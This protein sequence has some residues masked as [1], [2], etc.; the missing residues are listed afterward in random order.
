MVKVRVRGLV[1]MVRVGVRGWECAHVH[2]FMCLGEI[3]S[4]TDE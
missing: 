1:G 3:L 4:E 2:G